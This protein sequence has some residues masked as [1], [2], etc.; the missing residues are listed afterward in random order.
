MPLTIIFDEY[1]RNDLKCM[2]QG[3]RAMFIKKDEKLVEICLRRHLRHGI[4]AY[5]ENVDRDGRMPYQWDED[6]EMLRILRCFTN[7]KNY[8]KWYKSYKK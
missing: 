5:V 1:A 7:H 4:D 6:G 8:I 2:E 3:K